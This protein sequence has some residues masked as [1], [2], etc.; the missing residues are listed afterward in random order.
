MYELQ[1]YLVTDYR[2]H[3]S[4][5]PRSFPCPF[6]VPKTPFVSR[7][8]AAPGPARNSIV[9]SAHELNYTN[10]LSTPASD[11]L[12][13][14]HLHTLHNFI[15]KIGIQTTSDGSVHVFTAEQD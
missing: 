3:T 9:L 15:I 1:L 6:S 14:P 4:L 2:K 12:A 5:T 10:K 11:W 8:P 13:H 7:F